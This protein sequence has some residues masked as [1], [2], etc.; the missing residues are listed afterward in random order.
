MF[1]YPVWYYM[2]SCDMI[3][4]VCILFYWYS[5]STIF[6]YPV[7]Q[8]LRQSWVQYSSF[9]CVGRALTAVASIAWIVLP[10]AADHTPCICSKDRPLDCGWAVRRWGLGKE[11]HVIYMVSHNVGLGIL[12]G[13]LRAR[14][15][16]T[17]I[18]AW[19]QQTRKLHGDPRHAYGSIWHLFSELL[20]THV[21]CGYIPEVYT[22]STYVLLLFLLWMFALCV[23]IGLFSLLRVSLAEAVISLTQRPSSGQS[24]VAGVL[25]YPAHHMPSFL[26]PTRFSIP[27]FQICF[28][29]QLSPNFVNS[30]RS[31]VFCSSFICCARDGS[32][33]VY[34]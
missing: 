12:C 32:Y 21:T 24:V 30:P 25:P 10:Y 16:T 31:R 5:P 19:E 23:L 26:S 20:H 28:A 2:I 15:S 11:Q 18:T 34:C 9:L 14:E 7:S 29:R 3:Y 8:P 33:W 6:C 1:W 4:Q 13:K 17:S 27:T 22:M